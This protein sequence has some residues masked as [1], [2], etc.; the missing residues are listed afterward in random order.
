[1]Q[2]ECVLKKQATRNHGE[3]NKSQTKSKEKMKHETRIRNAKEKNKQTRE[4]LTFDKNFC[5]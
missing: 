5:R 2:E 1:M 4:C 3:N